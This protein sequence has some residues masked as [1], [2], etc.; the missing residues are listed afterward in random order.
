MPPK[1]YLW[2]SMWFL[3]VAPIILWD[4]GYVL[5]RSTSNYRYP[6]K[7]L[8]GFRPRS[9]EGGDLRWF[10]RIFEIYERVDEVRTSLLF[11]RYADNLSGLQRQGVSPE[12]WF[13]PSCGYAQLL[14]HLF[15]LYSMVNSCC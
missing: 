5:M 15:R 7:S 10:W 14:F 12:V 11:K 1:T 8:L 2:I 3:I 13:R 9:M 6:T 4:V